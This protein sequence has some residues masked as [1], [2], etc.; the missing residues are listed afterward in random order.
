MSKGRAGTSK[1]NFLPH[2]KMATNLENLKCPIFVSRVIQVT[3]YYLS[4]G[5]KRWHGLHPMTEEFFPRKRKSLGFTRSYE[6]EQVSVCPK[7]HRQ[8]VRDGCSWRSILGTLSLSA[9]T[10]GTVIGLDS[11]VFLHFPP[12]SSIQNNA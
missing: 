11:V 7:C 8:I 5:D 9:N 10:Q 4:D 3:K 2:L 6:L 12:P 1:A